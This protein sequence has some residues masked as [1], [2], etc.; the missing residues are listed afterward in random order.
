LLKEP[1]PPILASKTTSRIIVEASH[2]NTGMGKSPFVKPITITGTEKPEIVKS[3]D[4][5]K[6]FDSEVTDPLATFSQFA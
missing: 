3:A 4:E 5:F 2:R 6:R 1:L